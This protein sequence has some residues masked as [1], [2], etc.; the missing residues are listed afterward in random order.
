[1]LSLISLKNYL[2]LS[3]LWYIFLYA[4]YAFRQYKN[5]G[6]IWV[7][8]V[9][10]L[11]FCI[12]VQIE[13]TDLLGKVSELESWNNLTYQWTKVLGCLNI[14]PVSVLNWNVHRL[15]TSLFARDSNYGL[16]VVLVT[17][18]S[19]LN[20]LSRHIV[21]DQSQVKILRSHQHFKRLP[22]IFEKSCLFAHDV[23]SCILA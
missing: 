3:I 11:A 13:F 2:Y 6:T 8:E 18:F 23:L 15:Q 17:F 21:H 20:S 19:G 14:S 1:M 4:G 9:V 12:Q 7:C 22:V 10:E 5:F 16:G